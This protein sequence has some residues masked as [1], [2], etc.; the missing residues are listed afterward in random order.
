MSKGFHCQHSP[1]QCSPNS[2][3]RPWSQ[4]AQLRR[5]FSNN[6]YFTGLDPIISKKLHFKK[7]QM[8]LTK[9]KDLQT[10]QQSA[11]NG[12][13][14]SQIWALGQHLKMK[15]KESLINQEILKDSSSIRQ[16]SYGLLVHQ[17]T[18]EKDLQP[19]TPG[20]ISVQKAQILAAG[21]V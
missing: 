8:G 20:Q 17:K 7:I 2:P 19:P 3:T 11:C 12:G 10:P 1:K 13:G 21:H 15:K 18:H 6:Q 14:N 16:A 5:S 9:P 4:P